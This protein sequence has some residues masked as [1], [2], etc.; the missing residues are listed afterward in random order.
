MTSCD[1]LRL[2]NSL[3][4]S[5]VFWRLPTI[6]R[7]LLPILSHLWWSLGPLTTIWSQRTN[8]RKGVFSS[9]LSVGECRTMVLSGRRKISL[10]FS[11]RRSL[12][13]GNHSATATS[14]NEFRF[15][16]AIGRR[17]VKDHYRPCGDL[18]RL[19]TTHVMPQYK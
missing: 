8:D 3:W 5:V 10:V 6:M 18:L 12:I 19:V 11:N 17:P 14:T 13:V 1:Q 15:L 4:S 2:Q 9:L 16:L 7:W